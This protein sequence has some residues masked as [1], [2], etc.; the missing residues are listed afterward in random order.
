[1]SEKENSRSLLILTIVCLTLIIISAI[2]AWVYVKEQIIQKDR[3]FQQEQQAKEKEKEDS[4][5]RL[6]F[7]ECEERQRAERSSGQFYIAE[8]CELKL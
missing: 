6:K 8:N 5:K 1:M 3:Q 7:Q 2:G 4:L